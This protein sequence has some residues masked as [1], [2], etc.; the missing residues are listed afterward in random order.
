MTLQQ[1][2]IYFAQQGVSLQD[3]T[4]V[5]R[6]LNYSEV[7]IRNAEAVLFDTYSIYNQG[8]VIYFDV[9]SPL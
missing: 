6:T 1:L 5:F 7:D 9:E 8:S 3:M 2:A 4:S